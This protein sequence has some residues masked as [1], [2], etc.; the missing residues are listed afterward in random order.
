MGSQTS[1][2]PPLSPLSP[3]SPQFTGIDPSLMVRLITTLEHGRDVI[4]EQAEMIRRALTAAELSTARVGQLKEIEGWIDD[5]LPALRRRN[6][7]IKRP[8]MEWTPGLV[9]Y[10]ETACALPTA[11]D[12][13]ARGA[14]LARLLTDALPMQGQTA[15]D[16]ILPLIRQLATH[17]DDPDFATAFFAEL[18][19]QGSLDL[20]AQLT[21]ALHDPGAAIAIIGQ[22]FATAVQSGRRLPAFAAML[23]EIGTTPVTADSVGPGKPLRG[24]G[25]LLSGGDFPAGW[26][27]QVAAVHVLGPESEA[28]SAD[29][30]AGY[31]NALARNP[32][33]ARM[34]IAGATGD[35]VLSTFLGRMLDR[36]GSYAA[37]GQPAP[38]DAFGRMLAA[39]AGAYDEKDAAHSP[40]AAR[41]AYDLM[42]T[43]PNF[44][45]RPPEPGVQWP[46]LRVVRPIRVHLAEIA[47]A[48]ATEITEGASLGDVNRTQPSAFGKVTTIVPGLTPAFRL[49]PE[50]TYAFVKLFADSPDD[51]KPFETGM[52]SLTDRLVHTAATQ[53][54]GKSIEHLERVMHALGYVAGMQFAA[55]RKVQGVMDAADQERLKDEAFALGLSLGVGGLAIPGM[56]GQVLW[57]ALSTAAPAAF[58][59]LTSPTQTRLDALD[60]KTRL[61]DLAR[62]HW[63]VDTLMEN[64]FR[65]RTAPTDPQFAHPPITDKDGRLLPFEIIAKDEQT[66][67]NLN[68]WL[69]ANGSGGV[70]KTQ[71]G[72]AVSQLDVEFRGARDVAKSQVGRPYE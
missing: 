66:L 59:K 12:A 20:P 16:E 23:D 29:D 41:L 49:S 52:G 51:T 47:G 11:T 42:T 58:D 18:G 2:T 64:G 14:A 7:I 15:D 22:A 5:Q 32:A 43:L 39:A 8:V 26:L 60:D 33:A 68:N 37:N 10:D 55:E 72:E 57:L 70:S 61:A 45:N 53:D 65:A 40:D 30:L 54:A 63:L 6:D 21:G 1:G 44:D 3:L 31:M 69:I 56:Q 27:A 67:R 25:M 38:G 28:W 9:G 24:L 13:R 17:R 50:D 62:G 4:G 35:A 19:L 34:A 71:V 48:Y 36:V 46:W